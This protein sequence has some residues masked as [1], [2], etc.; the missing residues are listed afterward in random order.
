M[1]PYVVGKLTQGKLLPNVQ[2]STSSQ[3][4]AWLRTVRKFAVR[5]SYMEIYSKKCKEKISDLLAPKNR[6]QQMYATFE[7][8]PFLHM[9]FFPRYF[10]HLVF[11]ILLIL[12]LKMVVQ[13]GN[14][15]S[16]CFSCVWYSIQSEA[17]R[18][19]VEAFWYCV[20]TLLLVE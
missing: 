8:V 1:D 19:R 5:V 3:P 13:K 9:K 6:K 17:G 15:T 14:Y 2:L 7:V 18:K 20:E 4:S 11:E 16:I 10:D 12:Q